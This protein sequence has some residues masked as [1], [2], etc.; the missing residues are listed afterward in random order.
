V[1]V[2][3][4]WKLGR[5]WYAGRMNLEWRRPTLEEAVSVFRSVGLEGPFWTP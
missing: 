2:E 5:L 4:V 3:T 1:P